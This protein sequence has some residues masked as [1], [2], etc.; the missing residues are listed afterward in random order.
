VSMSASDFCIF[1]A[2]PIELQNII[3]TK[4]QVSG[5]REEGSG[6]LAGEEILQRLKACFDVTAA[7]RLVKKSFAT[8]KMCMQLY[9]YTLGVWKLQEHLVICKTYGVSSPIAKYSI[10]QCKV[11]INVFSAIS[12]KDPHAF[13]RG[14]KAIKDD[15]ALASVGLTGL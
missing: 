14:L 7:L 5:P 3:V 1:D 2:L 8:P 9:R 10:L 4:A 12:S 15:H 13:R 11:T 6:A